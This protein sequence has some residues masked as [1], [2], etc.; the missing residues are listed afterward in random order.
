MIVLGLETATPQVGCALGDNEGPVASFHL[1]RGRRHAET[2]APA[3]EYVCREA[4]IVL[5]DVGAVAVDI[6]PGLFTGLRVGVATGKALATALRIP[7][8]GLSS[9]D[10]LAYPHHRGEG[11]I[12]SVVD[13]RRGEVFWAL[14]RPVPGGV[15]R[16]TEYAVSSPEEVASELMAQGENTL[17]VGDGA[18][19][20]AEL[21]GR[22]DHVAVAGPDSAHPSALVLVDL[23]HPLAVREEFV[24]PS[25]V[26][27]LYLRTA[28]VRINWAERD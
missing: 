20:Y 21:L 12:A 19:R 8:I 11:L 9:L 18:C 15:Q 14:Y 13:A 5:G 16:V 22:V 26:A 7:M 4:G 23:A 6:G 17:A 27:P 2:L 28:D 24:A 10:L 3:I 25:E 1:S